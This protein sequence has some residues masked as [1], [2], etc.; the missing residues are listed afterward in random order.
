MNRWDWWNVH[1]TQII[2]TALVA[3]ALLA[4]AA[5]SM[6]SPSDGSVAGESPDAASDAPVE[7]AM[8]PDEDGIIQGSLIFGCSVNSVPMDT[9]PYG[10]PVDEVPVVDGQIVSGSASY[11]VCEDTGHHWSVLMIV[12]DHETGLSANAKLEAAGLVYLE[13]ADYDLGGGTVGFGWINESY[14]VKVTVSE[15][16]AVAA[17]VW[18]LR[19]SVSDLSPEECTWSG[20]EEVFP[21]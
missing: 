3:S 2:K 18:N 7:S 9:L 17:E 8:E 4:L 14:L 12:P 5:C 6:T 15:D 21:G 1:G 11:Q 19:Y 20:C 10:F 16:D 13:A